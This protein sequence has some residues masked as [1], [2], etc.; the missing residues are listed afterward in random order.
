[1]A[2]KKQNKKLSIESYKGVRDFYPEDMARQKYI[3]A[4]MR[5]VA[6][7]YGYVEYGAS[8]L[9]PS[10]LYRAKSGEEIVNEQTYTFTDRGDRSVTLRPEMTPTVARMIAGR[11]RELAFPLRWYS[12][13]N[14]FRYERPQRGRLREHV[15]LNVDLFGVEGL[16]A[17]AEVIALAHDIL[18]HFGLTQKQFSIRISF[19]GILNDILTQTYRIDSSKAVRIIKL[20]DKIIKGDEKLFE[21][22][23]FTRA[24][25]EELSETESS[26]LL[27]DLKSGAFAA[28][29]RTHENFHYDEEL[30]KILAEKNI[31]TEIHIWLTRGFDYYTGIIFEI[32]D[33]NPANSRSLLGGGRFDNLLDLFGVEKIPA[34][35]FGMG[36]VTIGDVLET[37]HLLPSYLSTT[38]LL[39]APM[40][41]TYIEAAEK[42]ADTLRKENINSALLFSPKKTSGAIKIAEKQSIP[43]AIIVGEAE[44]SGSYRLKNIISKEETTLS[45]H[46][47][48]PW[49][50]GATTQQRE[51]QT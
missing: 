37:Y 36:D 10:E 35:G 23:S 21:T 2:G 13:P 20:L 45:E 25:Q 11:R 1:M 38:H 46:E 19:A 29:A 32:F 30:Q 6:E 7:T 31:A 8:I 4:L 41:E 44:Q 40:D 22:E 5:E 24:L 51:E 33:T 43:Y 26:H 18:L 47:I 27:S 15:Q 42:L 3:F 17:D 28:H 12:I 14:L 50:K 16:H 9:E 34:V 48:A 49:I 39:I